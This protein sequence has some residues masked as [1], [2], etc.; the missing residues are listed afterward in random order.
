MDTLDAQLDHGIWKPPVYNVIPDFQHNFA[1][2]V[3]WCADGS[4]ALLQCENRSFQLFDISPGEQGP[5]TMTH[6]LTLPQ[7]SPIVDFVWYPSASRHNPPSYCFIASVRECPV[8]LLD[9]ND[10]RLRASYP[11]VDHRERQIAPHSLS[12]S[13][14]ADK[15]YCG[16]QDAIEIFDVQ[17]PG[18]GERLHTTPSKKSKD[19]LKG[20]VS[21]LAFSPTGSYLAAGTLTPATTTADNIA[22][23]DMSIQSESTQVLSMGGICTRENG[24]VIQLEF[25]QTDEYSVYATFR[26]SRRLWAWDLR[27]TL[28]PV[29]CFE[30]E[31][32]G[33]I[34]LSEKSTAEEVT[35]DPTNQKTHFDIDRGGR[36]IGMGDQIGNITIYD[37]HSQHFASSADKTMGYEADSEDDIPVIRPT[38]SFKAHQDAVGAVTFHPLQSVLLSVSGSRHFDSH[39]IHH[40]GGSEDTEVDSDSDSTSDVEGGEDVCHYE[41]SR[42]TF[43]RTRTRPRPG[44]RDASMKLWDFGKSVEVANQAE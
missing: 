16:F 15:L 40:Y 33:H 5:L 37:L 22:V 44:V 6:L 4:S 20:I 39:G 3:Q 9:G 31:E 28:A 11:I 30:L 26:R 29:C 18:E 14:T 24:G 13:P 38:L 25:S 8:K 7:P 12:F 19:G 27:N 41:R 42:D 1:R 10:G 36:W 34:V 2:T 17:R 35:K 21:A 32:P 23:Y 43:R